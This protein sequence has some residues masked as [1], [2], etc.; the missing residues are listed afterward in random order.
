MMNIM[1]VPSFEDQYTPM[2]VEAAARSEAS[3]RKTRIN[4]SKTHKKNQQKEKKT[5]NKRKKRWLDL[6]NIEIYR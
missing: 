3:K 6:R 5:G 2:F 4:I 1:T